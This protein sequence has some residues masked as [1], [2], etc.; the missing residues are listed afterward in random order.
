[1]RSITTA[2]L[3]KRT[4]T[5]VKISQN[6]SLLYSKFRHCYNNLSRHAYDITETQKY[7]LT[8]KLLTFNILCLRQ[9]LLLV[10]V[11]T[12]RKAREIEL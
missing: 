8:A 6:K 5:N 10:L 12:V 4:S 7:N 1:M 3:P 11:S 2:D 9:F